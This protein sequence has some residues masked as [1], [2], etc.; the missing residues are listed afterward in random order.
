MK[1]TIRR[2]TLAIPSGTR[3]SMIR[4]FVR[5]SDGTEYP[6][7]REIDI[8]NFKEKTLEFEC[9]LEGQ[10]KPEDITEEFVLSKE[11][12]G[13]LCIACQDFVTIL[14]K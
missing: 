4:T 14:N 10:P 1:K 8:P 7:D 2:Y 9:G 3:K 12:H 11:E 6:V 13:T 5:A